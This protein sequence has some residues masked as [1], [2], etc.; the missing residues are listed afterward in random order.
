MIIF[1][2]TVSNP[3]NVSFPPGALRDVLKA[4]KYSDITVNLFGKTFYIKQYDI[5][6]WLFLCESLW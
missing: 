5:P 4:K 2:V 1:L 6:K 3:F